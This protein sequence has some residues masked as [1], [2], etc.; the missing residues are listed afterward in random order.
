MH[1]QA[2]HVQVQGRCRSSAEALVFL[3]CRSKS[4]SFSSSIPLGPADLVHNEV[5][6]SG[7]A[8][9]LVHTD[10]EM[11]NGVEYVVWVPP[12]GISFNLI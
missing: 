7:N 12:S 9:T 1:D 11:T 3:W 5:G 2:E 6:A 10:I 8:V 4:Y